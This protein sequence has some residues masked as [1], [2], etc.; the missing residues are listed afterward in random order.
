M[1]TAIPAHAIARE[2]LREAIAAGR[3][4]DR[5]LMDE[6]GLATGL[7]LDETIDVYRAVKAEAAKPKLAADAYTADWINGI[8]VNYDEDTA[9]V[10]R[11]LAL[12]IKNGDH[13]RVMA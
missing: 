8:A 3:T 4:A 5:T 7:T 1:S 10:L 11:V 13:R 12:V 9:D 2:M 6:V